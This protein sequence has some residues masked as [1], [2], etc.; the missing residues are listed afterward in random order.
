MFIELLL[1]IG[2]SRWIILP[3]HFRKWLPTRANLATYARQGNPGRSL[4]R[5]LFSLYMVLSTRPCQ[6]GLLRVH[7]SD[8]INEVVLM[9]NYSVH[10]YVWHVQMKVSVRSPVVGVYL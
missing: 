4:G 6:L 3:A 7:F 2:D 8:G 10:G 1:F 5:F 9:D